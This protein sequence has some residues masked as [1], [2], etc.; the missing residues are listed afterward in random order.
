M[1]RAM[2]GGIGHR[3]HAKITKDTANTIKHNVDTAIT[4]KR[5]AKATRLL[6]NAVRSLLPFPPDLRGPPAGLPHESSLPSPGA[7]EE[8][9][10]H[11]DLASARAIL[12]T[13]NTG[14]VQAGTKKR[15]VY[16]TGK[17]LGRRHTKN[18][19]TGRDSRTRGVTS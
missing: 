17:G 15:H 9:H 10:D 8:P 16:W 4:S 6:A 11:N 1:L 2:K 7:A 18:V 5:N 19:I 13:Q 12:P 3:N 14:C